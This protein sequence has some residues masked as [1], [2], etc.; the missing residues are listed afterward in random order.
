[1]VNLESDALF[2]KNKDL[3][4]LS[5]DNRQKMIYYLRVKL[6]EDFKE[7]LIKKIKNDPKE[8]YLNSDLNMMPFH[9]NHGMAIRNLLRS[10]GFSEEKIG[11]DNLDNIYVEILE[12]V[13]N[14]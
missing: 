2:R 13:V 5:Q 1:M 7:E 8:W 9:F 14:V 11:I 12:E 4:N 10:G 6:P 3:K